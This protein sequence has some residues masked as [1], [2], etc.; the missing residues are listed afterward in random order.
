MKIFYALLVSIAVCGNVGFHLFEANAQCTASIAGNTTMCKGQTDTLIASGGAT[1]S[2]S[3]GQTTTSI[4]ISPTANTTYSVTATTGTC[5]A[6]ASIAVTVNPL[7]IANFNAP[8]VC[9]NN[10][11][12]FTDLSTGVVIWHWDFGDGNF[13]TQQSPAHTYNAP[14]TYTVTLVVSN[15]YGCTDTAIKNICVLPL[16]LLSVTVANASCTTCSN[17]SATATASGGNPPYTYSWSSGQS[18]QTAS[19]LQPGSYIITITDSSGCAETS[20]VTVSSSSGIN[21]ID[22]ANSISISPNPSSG[23]F[24]LQSSVAIKS[25]EVYNVL[26]GRIYGKNSMTSS[27]CTIDLSAEPEGIYFMRVN[28][29]KGIMSKK[30]IVIK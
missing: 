23:I 8:C 25:I 11:T 6:T 20:T 22:F 2:W 14:G 5:V 17:G 12:P 10:L 15:N 21:E 29:E 4:I 24:T 18:T 1:Y 30:M 27:P 13:S 28:T 7:P 19:N 9:F 3:T 26:G 16:P